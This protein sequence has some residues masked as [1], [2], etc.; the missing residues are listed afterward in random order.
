[1][2]NFTN[3]GGK[4][5]AKIV[6]GSYDGEIISAN[7][8]GFLDKKNSFNE[9]HLKGDAKFVQIPDPKIRPVLYITGPSGAG[10]ST[11]CKNFA[12]EWLK[13][14]KKGEIFVFSSLKDDESLDEIKKLSRIKLDESLFDDPIDIDDLKDSLCIF[15]DID[16]INNKKIRSAVYSILDQCLEIGRHSNIGVL[17]TNHMA[18]GGNSTKRSLNECQ[19]ITFFK[20]TN[21][22]GLKYLTEKYLGI[23]KEQLKYIKKLKSRWI[24][25]FKN[26]PETVLAE[27]DIYTLN[28]DS[29]DEYE[30]EPEPEPK[31]KKSVKK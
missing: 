12:K 14:N 3:K 21:T 25:V 8:E 28:Q 17:V 9:L 31:K 24:T 29:E 5:I 2:L 13:Q 15:D 20:G 22:Y 19:T 16:V 6:G 7:G 27:R 30:S 26:Y 23:S 10:K 1:M 18:T 4:Q 11:Y